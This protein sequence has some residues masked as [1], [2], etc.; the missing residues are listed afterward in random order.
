MWDFKLLKATQ[1]LEKTMAYMIYRLGMYLVLSLVLIFGILAG[2][3]FGL[4]LDSMF[5]KSDFFVG[6]GGI[7]GFV[8]F[9]FIFYWFRGSW[10]F[11]MRAPHVA[12][13]NEALGEA[14]TPQGWSQVAHGR[15]RVSERFSTADELLVL[16][17]RIKATLAYLFRRST[18]IGQKLSGLGDS[19][20]SRLLARIAEIPAAFSDEIILGYC[21]NDSSRSASAAAIT[22]LTLFAQNFRRLFRNA[23]ALLTF[24]YLITF[25]IFLLMLSPVG[26]V[27]QIIP[28]EFGYWRYVFAA[29]M[30]W[31]LKSAL[32]D[33]IVVAAM[34]QVFA[35]V[36]AGQHI[37]PNWVADLAEHSPEFAGL[38]NQAEYLEAVAAK[39][40]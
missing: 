30:T 13:L 10:L 27:D 11:S 40:G 24:K 34:M 35:D 5:S 3:G 18:A 7:A 25:I 15:R 38:K 36:T 37:E 1:T 14:T 28:V 4:I 29:L 26:W 9:A 2:T 23:I 17:K 8:V 20:S 12:L 16:D 33:P 21:L 6:V 31:P 32:F 39:S 22:G 19:T